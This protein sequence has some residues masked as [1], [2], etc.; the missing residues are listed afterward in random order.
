M[1]RSSCSSDST[2]A[3][4]EDARA[5]AGPPFFY[6]WVMVPLAMAG[7]VASAPGQTFGVAP[8]NPYFRETLGLSESQLTGAYMLGTFLASLPMRYV[9]AAMDRWGIR[10]TKTA[11]ILLFGLTCIA[12]SQVTGLA[13]LFL[14]FIALRLF[15]QGALGL[16]SGNT[17]AFWFERRLGTVE[18]LRNLGVAGAV[19]VVPGLNLWLI[20]SFGWRW[21][22]AILGLAVWAVMLPA[23][24]LFRNRPED[25]GQNKDNR[26]PEAPQNENADADTDAEANNEGAASSATQINEDDGRFDFTPAQVRRTRAFWLAMIP[27]ATWAMTNTA[28]QFNATPLLLARGLSESTVPMLFTGFAIGF[29]VMIMVGGM[30]ADRLPLNVLLSIGSACMTVGLGLIYVVAAPWMV[31]VSGVVLGL[32]QGLIVGA[33]APLWPRYFGRTHLGKLRGGLVTIMVASSS[34]GPFLMGG[35]K[36]LIGSYDPILLIFALLPLPMIVAT[37]WAT[38]PRHPDRDAAEVA[39]T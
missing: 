19:A 12:A 5:A 13:G 20:Q 35:G 26:P 37:L 24:L 9:G 23:M 31:A 28:V 27:L 32:T 29:A 36:D 11:V 8:F 18:G 33:A 22:Y 25:V 4:P 34:A 2:T 10:K 3:L 15:G 6:G 1:S 7:I 14:A 21:A 17:L 30:L 39:Q 16:L 38:P